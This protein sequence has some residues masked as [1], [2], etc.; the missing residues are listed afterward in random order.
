MSNFEIAS[1]NR[2]RL[3]EQVFHFFGQLR[4]YSKVWFN[5]PEL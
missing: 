4:S 1:H 3:S 2:I 5:T